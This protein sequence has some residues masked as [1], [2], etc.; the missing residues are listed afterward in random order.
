MFYYFNDIFLFPSQRVVDVDILSEEQRKRDFRASYLIDSDD[1]QL[2]LQRKRSKVFAVDTIPTHPT[3]ICKPYFTIYMSYIASE[4]RY[5][6]FIQKRLLQLGCG[7]GGPVRFLNSLTSNGAL[8]IEEAD[9]VVAFLSH[10]YMASPKDLEEFHYI[11][12]RA[13]TKSSH[14]LYP[15]V[16]DQLPESPIYARLIP[17]HC[18]L[19]DDLWAEMAQAR[20]LTLSNIWL[21]NQVRKYCY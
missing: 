7:L 9:L 13:R 11:L 4:Q 2:V 15:I 8:A 14:F 1:D 20:D 16:I 3:V 19:K 10:S 21:V 6:D 17:T 5:A 12:S 18:H